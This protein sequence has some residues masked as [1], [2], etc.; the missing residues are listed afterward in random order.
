MILLQFLLTPFLFS[1]SELLGGPTQWC[2][3]GTITQTTVRNILL[4]ITQITFI[5]SIFNYFK[6]FFI[7]FNS[8]ELL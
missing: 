6:L 3:A 1:N 4:K 8:F 7:I 5:I 2:V